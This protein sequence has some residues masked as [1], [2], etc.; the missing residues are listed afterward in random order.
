MLAID[1][2]AR[3]YGKLPHEFLGLN[4]LD[5]SFDLIVAQ[6]ALQEERRRKGE[7]LRDLRGKEIPCPLWFFDF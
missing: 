2:L 7:V 6:I 4:P 5:F 1:R 3:R